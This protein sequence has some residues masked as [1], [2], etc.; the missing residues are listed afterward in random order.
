[1]SAI[2][3]TFIIYKFLK[4]LVTPFNKTDAFK[5][6]IIDKKGKYLKKERESSLWGITEASRFVGLQDRIL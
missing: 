2:V 1:M 5:L 3:N 4:L 6:G